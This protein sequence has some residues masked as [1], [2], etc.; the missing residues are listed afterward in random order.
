MSTKIVASEAMLI[1]VQKIAVPHRSGNKTIAIELSQKY[2]HRSSLRVNNEVTQSFLSNLE[3]QH[4]ASEVTLS[5][6]S[7]F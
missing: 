6:Q 7:P 3:K 4:S 1:W 2:D 5:Y